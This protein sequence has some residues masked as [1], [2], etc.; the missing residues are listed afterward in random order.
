MFLT[1]ILAATS[2]SLAGNWS[3]DLRASPTVPAYSQPM[4]L[5]VP[6]DGSLT[7]T[8]YG[9]PITSGRAGSS[10]GRTC[11]AFSTSDQ[12]APD[13]HS[14]CV[15]G[16]AIEGITWSAGRKFLLAWGATRM[17]RSAK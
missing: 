10:N 1:M 17:P 4:S 6:D 5:A 7:G 9:A 8:F 15:R 2:A 3:A 13:Q 14:G 12:S 11:F 16:E